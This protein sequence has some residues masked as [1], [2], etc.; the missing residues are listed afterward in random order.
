MQEVNDKLLQELNDVQNKIYEIENECKY[1]QEQNKEYEIQTHHIRENYDTKINELQQV[2]KEKSIEIDQLE[3][4]YNNLMD[5]M[6]E[7][8]AHYETVIAKQ[9]KMILPQEET[10]IKV[11]DYKS[12]ASIKTPIDSDLTEKIKV[13]QFMLHDS[14]KSK[15]D[16][17]AICQELLI[18]LTRREYENS[19]KQPKP[20]TELTPDSIQ[21]IENQIIPTDQIDAKPEPVEPVFFSQNLFTNTAPTETEELFEAKVAYKCFDNQSQG[22]SILVETDDLWGTEE[23]QLEAQHVQT[24]DLVEKY[25]LLEKEHQ[26]LIE[27]Y[28]ALKRNS[29][30]TIKKLKESNKEKKQ[31]DFSDD[32]DMAIVDELKLQIENWEKVV[33]ELKQEKDKYLIERESLLKQVDVSIYKKEF[34]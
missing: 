26:D 11:I 30:K 4:N 7:T 13:L 15:D 29:I 27:K 34:L 8:N 2:I 22:D 12:E 21:E 23:A 19:T 20:P 17:I 1:A 25:N 5:R 10:L 32:L 18:E 9:E 14:E 31:G 24:N 33:K 16:A 6:N 28:K 3:V